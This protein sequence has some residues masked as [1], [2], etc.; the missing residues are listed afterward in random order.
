MKILLT[1]E[2]YT[3]LLQA[4]NMLIA[5]QAAGVDNW[6]G[7]ELALEHYEDPNILG[8]PVEIETLITP[9]DKT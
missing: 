1:R 3:E 4:E 7:H 9:E 2:R 5:L 6:E 8:I